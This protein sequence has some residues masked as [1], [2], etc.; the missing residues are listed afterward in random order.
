MSPYGT[1]SVDDDIDSILRAQPPVEGATL[2][3]WVAFS[4]W[5]KPT[6]EM[7]LML[8]G[9][10]EA[11]MLRLKAYLHSGL[12]NMVWREYG[13]PAEVGEPPDASAP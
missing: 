10:P 8:F 9:K 4:E 3:G 13:D 7:T 2:E 6:G 11:N 1:T 5:K 12:L